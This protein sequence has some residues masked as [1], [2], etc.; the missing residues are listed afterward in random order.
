MPTDFISVIFYTLQQSVIIFLYSIN[1][2][3]LITEMDFIYCGVR[4]ESLNTI[5]V[6]LSLKF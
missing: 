5:N 1:M 4:N 6:V 3:V 2:L